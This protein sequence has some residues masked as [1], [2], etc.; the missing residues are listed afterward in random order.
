MPW[1]ASIMARQILEA[2]SPRAF[3]VEQSSA[4]DWIVSERR[5]GPQGSFA[6][7]QAAIHFV[8]F[9]FGAHKAS[10]LLMPRRVVDAGRT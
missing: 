8:L 2:S 3:V 5:S 4:G 9:E 1:E 7:Q 6:S 10:V